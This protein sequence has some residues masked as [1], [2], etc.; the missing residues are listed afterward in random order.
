MF[1]GNVF[2]LNDDKELIKFTKFVNASLKRNT[3]LSS[4]GNL[5]GR[6]KRSTS[7]SREFTV[8]DGISTATV[9]IA[10]SR[11][12]MASQVSLV[13]PGNKKLN[14]QT[15]TSM[16]IIFEIVNPKAGHYQINFPNTVGKYEYNVQGVSDKAIEFTGSFTHQQ[17]P[18]KDSPTISITTPFKG[19]LI[20]S[21]TNLLYSG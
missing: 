10:V 8:D 1:P 15:T 18:L 9:S 3:L 4:G 11:P 21:N 17:N 5:S 2:P 14:A 12:N 7:F 19:E 13:G 16:S 20:Y 6:K